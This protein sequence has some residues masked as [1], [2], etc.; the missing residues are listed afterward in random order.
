MGHPKGQESKSSQGNWLSSV[1]FASL[2]SKYIYILVV[3]ICMGGVCFEIYVGG[4]GS[5]GKKCI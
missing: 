4:K 2:G 3:V 1:M 5:E